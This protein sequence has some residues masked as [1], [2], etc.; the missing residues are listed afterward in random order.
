MGLTC[1]CVNPNEGRIGVGDGGPPP[2]DIE[3][4]EVMDEDEMRVGVFMMLL[5]SDR[6]TPS[7]IFPRII[8][9]NLRN[10]NTSQG[11]LFSWHSF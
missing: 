11:T 10:F 6:P 3:F 8:S 5:D 9:P 4:G 7:H 1:S 2:S